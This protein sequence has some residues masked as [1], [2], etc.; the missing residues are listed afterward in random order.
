MKKVFCAAAVAT[1][2]I[3]WAAPAAAQ[4]Q[5]PVQRIIVFGDSLSD[6][7]F[8]GPLLGIPPALARFTTNPDPVAPEVTAAL[9]GLPLDTVYGRAGTNYAV[10]GARVT[11]PNGV[12]IPITNQINNFIAAGG[13]FGP[14]DLVYIQGGGNDFFAFQAGG[15]VDNS[16]LTTAANQLAAQVVRVQAAGAERIVTF[17]VQ[18]GGMAGLA[19]FNQTYATALATANVNALYFNTDR[20]FNE[21]IA[22]PAQFGIR[23]VFTPACTVSSLGCSAANFREPGANLTYALADDVHPSGITQRIQ[24]QAVASLLV[25]PEQI[26]QLGYAGQALMRGH[27]EM[28]EGPMRGT[29][30]GEGARLFG[31]V[32]YDSF[33]INGSAQRVGVDQDAFTFQVGVDFPLGE[34]FGA[35]IVGAYSQGEGEFGEGRGGYDLSAWSVTGYLRGHVGP[36]HLGA[37]GTYGTLDY[38]DVARVV[39]LG[40]SVRT[41]RGDTDGDYMAASASVEIPVFEIA[42]LEIG[43]EAAITYERLEI[44]GYV[45]DSTLST[46]ATFGEQS[47]E[48]VTGRA[49]IGFAT[50]PELGVRIAG[51]FSYE[52]ELDGEE[53][54]ISITPAGAPIDY[55]SRIFTAEDDYMSTAVSVDG[56]ITSRISLRGGLRAEFGR[57]DFDSVTGYGGVAIAF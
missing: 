44:D 16:I 39:V 37:S 29:L 20:L 23:Q 9:L 33:N 50:G 1:A 8:Y 46:A 45:E 18:T 30:T 14:N 54:E 40:P 43:P 2:A 25:A 32:A 22:N 35:G 3:A 47:V 26:G 34:A 41:H 42:G 21:I 5:R 17:A 49:G 48:S 56:P 11:L 19:L 12:T 24:G 13:R 55:T 51:R 4:E 36:V 7:G 53:R 27:R 10:G 38:S 6:G 57:A 31:H 28:L 52:T 15:S